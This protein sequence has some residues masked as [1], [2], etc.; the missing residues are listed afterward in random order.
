MPFV[1]WQLGQAPAELDKD[2][3]LVEDPDVQPE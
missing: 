2:V 1:Q 3:E